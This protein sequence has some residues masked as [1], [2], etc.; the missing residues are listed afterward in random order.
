M[1]AELNG[2]GFDPNTQH[3][4][5]NCHKKV[6]GFN[7]HLAAGYCDDCYNEI[8]RQSEKIDFDEEW[9]TKTWEN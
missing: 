2:D 1:Y 6:P 3:Y 5:G 4:C 7:F 8:E 9:L